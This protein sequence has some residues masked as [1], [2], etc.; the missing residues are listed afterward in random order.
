MTA[1]GGGVRSDRACAGENILKSRGEA[2]RNYIV[3][4]F[5]LMIPT[6]IG[7]TFVT[8]LLCQFVPGG[9]IDQLRLQLAG[10]GG[11]GEGAGGGGGRMPPLLIPDAQLKHV[12]EN[13]GFCKPLPRGDG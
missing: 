8:F 6:F 7:I 3:R 12:S 4:R 2:L 5:L 13:Y 11:G 10:A 9:P 1:N